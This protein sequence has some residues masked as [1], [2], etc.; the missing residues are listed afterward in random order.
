MCVG[1]GERQEY[2]RKRLFFLIKSKVVPHLKKT[3]A[4]NF[5]KLN[6]LSKSST[7]ELWF[8]LQTRGPFKAGFSEN[9][10]IRLTSQISNLR[11]RMGA[12]ADQLH[13]K[14]EGTPEYTLRCPSNCY[15]TQT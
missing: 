9:W 3:R 10:H 12:G 15:P 6:H 5:L 4:N 7:E 2:T 13:I 8:L 14:Q 1:W 11:V